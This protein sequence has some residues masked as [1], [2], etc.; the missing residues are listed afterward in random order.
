MEI[1]LGTFSASAAGL[2]RGA[3]NVYKSHK[4]MQKRV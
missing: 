3:D 1:L 4:V 2:F